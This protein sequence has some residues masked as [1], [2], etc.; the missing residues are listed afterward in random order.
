MNPRFSVRMGSLVTP[1]QLKQIVENAQRQVAAQ[2]LVRTPFEVE[3]AVQAQ[4][5]LRL[6]EI[7]QRNGYEAISPVKVDPTTG[8]HEALGD[9]LRT[10]PAEKIDPNTILMRIGMREKLLTRFKRSVT[11]S[12][13]LL[14]NGSRLSFRSRC[15]GKSA[16]LSPT[17][18]TPGR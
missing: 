8:A 16:T 12:A 4:V 11:R 17:S 6:Y 1:E 14:P 10:V 7:A 2:N 9:L 5:G 13:S 3:S 18:S 15:A